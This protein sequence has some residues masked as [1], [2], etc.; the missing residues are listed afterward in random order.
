[1]VVDVVKRGSL[2][3]VVR[4]SVLLSGTGVALG[5]T[6]LMLQPGGSVHVLVGAGAELVVPFRVVW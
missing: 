4:M 1:M 6:V 5:L 3:A 2:V